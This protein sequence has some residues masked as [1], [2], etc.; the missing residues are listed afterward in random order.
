MG[1]GQFSLGMIALSPARLHLGPTTRMRQGGGGWWTAGAAF[2]VMAG[3]GEKLLVCL[4]CSFALAPQ[5]HRLHVD[6]LGLSQADEGCL[7]EVGARFPV[8]VSGHA[9][10]DAV[11]GGKKS[12]SATIDFQLIRNDRKFI[13]NLNRASGEFEEEMG[14]F[15]VFEISGFRVLEAQMFQHLRECLVVRSI[16]DEVEI[17]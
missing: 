6:S 11:G 9:V 3:L 14:A 1:L 4:V 10:F 7:I 2:L 17:T 16:Q 15:R 12:Q 13:T 8:D 5:A